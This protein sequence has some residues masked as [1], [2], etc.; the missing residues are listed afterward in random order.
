MASQPEDFGTVESHRSDSRRSF[1]HENGLRSIKESGTMSSNR[2][3]TQ[4]TPQRGRSTNVMTTPSSS[5]TRSAQQPGMLGSVASDTISS[6]IQP[7]NK[8]TSSNGRPLG[9]AT[10]NP[11]VNAAPVQKNKD[12]QENTRML[13]ARMREV[14]PARS[15]RSTTFPAPALHQN[16]ID[17]QGH[18]AHT[19]PKQQPYGGSRYRGLTW[20]EAMDYQYEAPPFAPALDPFILQDNQPFAIRANTSEFQLKP[21]GKGVALIEPERNNG[22]PRLRPEDIQKLKKKH[23]AEM[24]PRAL[25]P[26]IRPR[27]STPNMRTQNIQP[28]SHKIADPAVPFQRPPL[29]FQRRPSDGIDPSIPDSPKRLPIRGPYPPFNHD[30]LTPPLQTKKEQLSSGRVQGETRTAGAHWDPADR[31]RELVQNV[32]NEKAEP[33]WPLPLQPESDQEGAPAVSA[34][35]LP[36]RVPAYEG[37]A[38]SA[39]ALRK[40]RSFFGMFSKSKFK[41]D[42]KT[43]DEEESLRDRVIAKAQKE[44]EERAKSKAAQKAE[45]PL[46]E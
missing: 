1:P 38:S 32:L 42:I 2:A 6:P 29:K 46:L 33:T 15:N 31:P 27:P 36:S 14:S 4:G 20:Q 45:H 30:S 3:A 12:S 5:P 37:P 39:P 17:A 8:Y 18:P 22:A 35:A 21:K 11:R 25:P 13:V 44:R 9:Y 43:I 28:A 34:P 24:L 19:V 40:K 41:K 16:S 10:S 7:R 23:S 26:T